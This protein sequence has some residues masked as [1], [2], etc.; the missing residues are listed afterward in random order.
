M[1]SYEVNL[2][3][4]VEPRTDSHCGWGRSDLQNL[5]T[6]VQ[7]LHQGQAQAIVES[8]HGGPGHCIVHAVRPLW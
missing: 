7:A 5:S 2:S 4:L 1:Q 8:Q 3:V 6:T